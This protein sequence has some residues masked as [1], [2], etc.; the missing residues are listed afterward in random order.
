MK[1]IEEILKEQ[2]AR[3]TVGNNWAVW[4]G[5][6]REWVVYT[7]TYRAHNSKVIF[8]GDCE[9]AAFFD[10]LVKSIPQP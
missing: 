5:F 7:H 3:I 8:R 6:N 4:D 10:A 1:T 9:S 2:E